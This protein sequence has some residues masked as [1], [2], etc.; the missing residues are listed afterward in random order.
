M[1][2]AT[3]AVWIVFATG[4]LAGTAL[5]LWLATMAHPATAC[6]TGMGL[7]ALGYWAIQDREE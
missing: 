5:G 3:V 2:A 1:R 7:G 4:L 6:V